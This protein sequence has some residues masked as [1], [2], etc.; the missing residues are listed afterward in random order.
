MTSFDQFNLIGRDATKAREFLPGDKQYLVTRGVPCLRRAT[1]LA[2]TGADE[3][4]ERLVS[5]ADSS[6]P[7]AEGDEWVETHAGRVQSA[8]DP[9]KIWIKSKVLASID[10]DPLFGHKSSPNESTI[11]LLSLP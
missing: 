1:S 8:A 7:S 4:A 10:S 6:A 11:Q 9:T 2:Y 5:F 3:D